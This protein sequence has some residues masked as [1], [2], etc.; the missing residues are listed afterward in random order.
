V[1]PHTCLTFLGGRVGETTL[2]FTQREKNRPSAVNQVKTHSADSRKKS[3]RQ[4]SGQSSARQ[5]RSRGPA[6]AREVV[7]PIG[8]GESHLPHDVAVVDRHHDTPTTHIDA[9]VADAR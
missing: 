8:L 3:F 2:M 7:A 6:G 4:T 5:A 9:D 1:S